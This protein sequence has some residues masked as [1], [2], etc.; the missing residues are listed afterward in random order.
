MSEIMRQSG[1]MLRPLVGAD[2]ERSNNKST[3]I[4][5]TDHQMQR[6]KLGSLDQRALE[7][8][9][10]T[11]HFKNDSKMSIQEGKLQKHG[12]SNVGPFASI[13]NQN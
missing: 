10:R 12:K 1:P 13:L 5:T 7:E 4:T 8:M 2:T 6:P 11:I 3:N 9:S